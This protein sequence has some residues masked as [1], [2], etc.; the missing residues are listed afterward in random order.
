MSAS[1]SP[2]PIELP[3]CTAGPEVLQESVQSTHSTERSGVRRATRVRR[4]RLLVRSRLS[5][6]VALACLRLRDVLAPA[7]CD[8]PCLTHRYRRGG[9]ASLLCQ[10]GELR[11]AA[12]GYWGTYE[13]GTKV[14]LL[15]SSPP[16]F[17][18]SVPP[19]VSQR[20]SFDVLERILLLFFVTTG[21]MRCVLR[22]ILNGFYLGTRIPHLCPLSF[23]YGKMN[24]RVI[25]SCMRR[26]FLLRGA[27]N[28]HCR[29]TVLYG[30][31][32]HT[33]LEFRSGRTL[34]N[35]RHLFPFLHEAWRT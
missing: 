34:R 8:R 11:E 20:F 12:R 30:D 27:V 9:H 23:A 21:T 6:F 15:I 19:S 28:P 2:V 18:S 22:C 31:T 25:I 14:G 35:L 32:Q 3:P 29:A 26:I 17:S 1:A 24:K 33:V 10:D 5:N 16:C 4:E 13:V 7:S